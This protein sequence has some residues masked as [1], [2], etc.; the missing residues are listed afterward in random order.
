MKACP[1]VI[2]HD[3]P[4]RRVLAFEHPLAGRQVVKGGLEAGES[5]EAAAV[6]E[7]HEETGLRGRAVRTLGTRWFD[8]PDQDWVFVEVALDGP[9]PER[10]VHATRDGGGLD[11]ACFWQP[12]DE[13]EGDGW[14]PLFRDAL[15]WLRARLGAPAQPGWASDQGRRAGGPAPVYADPRRRAALLALLDDGFPGLAARIEAGRAA[16]FDWDAVTEPFVVEEDGVPVAHVGVIAHRAALAGRVVEVAGVHAVCVRGDRRGRGLARRALDE[17]LAWADARFPLA[18]LG[19]DVPAVYAPHGFVARPLHRFHVD[20]AGGRGAGRPLGA[21]ERAWFLQRCAARDPV[22]RV[23]ASLDPGW[24]VGIDLAL[25][26]RS[27]ADL[28]VLDDLDA[29]VDWSV[30]DGVLALHDV[31]A[32][33]LPPLAELLDRAPPH[34]AAC[35]HV[36][37]DRLAPDARPEVLPDAGVWMFRPDPLGD[38][39]LAVGR[40]AEH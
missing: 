37:P 21:H 10:W 35:L 40:L 22:S 19:T 4:A 6:R 34:R 15:A 20:H 17:A 33:S 38:A 3:G 29:V 2:S 5:P 32:L 39:P 30:H 13:P 8:G 1:V 23:C 26:R 27:L 12:L 36:C 31:F 24:L 11:F 28:V 25:Q 7:L 18:K 14:H 9:A 16:G